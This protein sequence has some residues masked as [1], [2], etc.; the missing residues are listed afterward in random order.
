M[1]LENTYDLRVTIQAMTCNRMIKDLFAAR[2][3]ELHQAVVD[4]LKTMVIYN[5]KVMSTIFSCT[6]E[7]IIMELVTKFE[8]GKSVIDAIILK[9]N[10]R[11]GKKVLRES[12]RADVEVHRFRALMI[13]GRI[14]GSELIWRPGSA[15]CCAEI[16]Q[17]LRERLWKHPVEAITQPAVFHTVSIGTLLSFLNDRTA[18]HRHFEIRWLPGKLMRDGAVF[19]EGPFHVFLGDSTSKGLTH[20]EVKIVTENIL[21]IKISKLLDI[22]KWTVPTSDQLR[23]LCPLRSCVPS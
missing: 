19:T 5:P 8:S 23:D 9:Q 13:K 18:D 10:Y 7:G 17:N 6:P 12:L 16:V 2:R 14:R 1:Y 4:A 21:A 22:Y 20:P 11:K 15:A 3:S